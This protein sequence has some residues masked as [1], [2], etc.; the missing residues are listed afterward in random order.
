[1]TSEQIKQRSK[2]LNNLDKAA[3]S[4]N[5]SIES[6]NDTVDSEIG[7]VEFKVTA[8]EDARRLLREFV[9]DFKEKSQS[10][11]HD[12]SEAWQDSKQ[13]ENQTNL[14]EQ[15]GIDSDLLDCPCGL[16]RPEP[17]E[18]IENPVKELV[19]PTQPEVD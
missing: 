4:L 6:Y 12:K 2:L 13:G 19:I 5:E 14:I 8:F 16:G 17:M 3:N 10:E 11:F 15:L 7:R 18:V 9:E 1:M